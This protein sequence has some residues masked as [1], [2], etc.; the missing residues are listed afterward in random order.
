MTDSATIAS[1]E[2]FI[3]PIPVSGGENMVGVDGWRVVDL[4]VAA[5]QQEAIGLLQ[6]QR[7]YANFF[8]SGVDDAVG[9]DL[10]LRLGL[11]DDVAAAQRGR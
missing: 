8:L 5:A 11:V 7:L 2:T 3:A 9:L 10:L 6:T 1:T 4:V